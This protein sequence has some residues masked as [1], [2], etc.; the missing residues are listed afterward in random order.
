MKVFTLSLLGSNSN[1]IAGLT[2][3]II[4]LLPF[5]TLSSVPSTSILIRFGSQYE[6]EML[7]KVT[8]LIVVT[9]GARYG[10]FQ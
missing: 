3:F 1:I 4:L 9:L 6:T 7:S 2:F 5:S 10:V 8:I